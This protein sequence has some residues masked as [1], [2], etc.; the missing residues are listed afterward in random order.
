MNLSFRLTKD[1]ELLKLEV[2]KKKERNTHLKKESEENFQKLL[3]Q[4]KQQEREI[5]NNQ[6][7]FLNLKNL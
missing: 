5:E 6:V 3:A 2:E 7:C 4:T 1:V